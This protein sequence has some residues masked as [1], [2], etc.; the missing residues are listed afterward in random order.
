MR[1]L[2]W[3]KQTRQSFASNNLRETKA[4]K[5]LEIV[6][7]DIYGPMEISSIGG[8]KYFI[9]FINDHSRYLSIYFL[10][11]KSE[12]LDAFKTYK[13]YVEKKTGEQILAL[14]SD[15]GREFVNQEFVSF[16]RKEGIQHQFTIPCTP[17]QNGREK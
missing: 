14:R 5:L 2:C 8:T 17:E 4:S 11:S 16:L 13:K 12:A 7:T 10:N 3:G 15:N 9:L 6:H 1:N